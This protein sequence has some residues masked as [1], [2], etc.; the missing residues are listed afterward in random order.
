MAGRRRRRCA[1]IGREHWLRLREIQAG[2]RLPNWGAAVLRPYTHGL[3]GN[4]SWT[5]A[6]AR[7]SNAED[8]YFGGFDEGGGAFAGLQAHLL[9]GI[10]RDEGGD[11]LLADGQRD[12]RQ[13]SA[14]LDG[15]DAADE[16]V[17]PA[18]FAEIAAPRGDIAALQFLRDQAVDLRF[19]DAMVAAGR[20]GAFDLAVID[21]LLQRGI[22]DAENAGGFARC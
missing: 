6:H 14:E 7:C 9:G 22:T 5:L 10:G 18:D 17:A 15:D 1:G 4:W 8:H 20:L 21:P 12:L 19:R 2:A 11:V 13:E 16:L 3:S